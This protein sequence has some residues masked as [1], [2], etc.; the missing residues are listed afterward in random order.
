MQ[1]TGLNRNHID[2]FYTLPAVAQECITIWK[3]ILHPVKSDI[4]IEPSAG[5][6]SF[7]LPLQVEFPYLEG[8]DIEP[9]HQNI[10][11]RDFLRV[12]YQR[13]AGEMVHVIGNPPFGRQSSL[14]L[15]FIRTS[16]EFADTIS[17]ILPKSFK[18]ESLKNKIPLYFHLLHEMELS[19]PAFCIGDKSYHV[20]CVFQI[21]VKTDEERI[22]DIALEY[23]E[24]VFVKKNQQP[25]FAVR[26]VGVYAGRISTEIEELSV[27]T[28]YFLRFLPPY[29]T[30]YLD[31]LELTFSHNNTVGP[32]SISKQELIVEI[33]RCLR[34]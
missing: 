4:I 32:R 20:P 29:T 17:F 2:K 5:S 18:K 23:N 27:S 33:Q 1:D 26:R 11:Q 14:A 10:I 16:A 15:Q 6:G 9:D 13:I 30:D 22:R 3:E 28:H 34:Q 21:W 19:E 24:F 7:F 25:H 12:P 8:Y 31:K